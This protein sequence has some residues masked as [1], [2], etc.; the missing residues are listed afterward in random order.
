MGHEAAVWSVGKRT[1]V[2]IAR[3]PRQDVERL[4]SFVQASLR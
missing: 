2:L 1:F 3:E 4:A